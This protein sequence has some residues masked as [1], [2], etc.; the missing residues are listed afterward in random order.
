MADD[1]PFYAPDRKPAAPRQSQP[2]HHLWTLTKN[3][4]R[5]ECE[6]RIFGEW[7]AECQLLK[8]GEFYT[9]RRFPKYTA[10]VQYAQQERAALEQGAWRDLATPGS[11]VD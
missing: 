4:R 9:D 2:E 6:I 3:G 10:A 8:N 1:E 11:A 5:T 7:G